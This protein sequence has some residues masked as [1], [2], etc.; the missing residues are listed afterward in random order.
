M[1]CKSVARSQNRQ[2]VEIFMDNYSREQTA[3]EKAQR[4]VAA[5]TN[6]IEM[7]FDAQRLM[8]GEIA[9]AGNEWIDR[10]RSEAHLLSEFLSKLAE[11]HSV[12]G[13]RTMYEECRQHQVDFMRRDLDRL[14]RRGKRMIEVSSRLF[15]G[16]PDL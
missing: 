1:S 8:L 6:L 16:R 10:T 14:L 11:A 13:L 4:P 15:E 7:M 2:K 12:N 5:N 9:F 3:T